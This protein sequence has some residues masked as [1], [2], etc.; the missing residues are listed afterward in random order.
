V[1]DTGVG[2][3]RGEQHKLFGRFEQ[4]HHSGAQF[5]SGTG[6]GLALCKQL[7]E[8]NGGTIGFESDEGHGSTFYFT[9]PAFVAGADSD[10]S[11]T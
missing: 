5:G 4:V 6:L 2:I 8:L 7:V 11:V 1:Q 10:E 3:P 9:L